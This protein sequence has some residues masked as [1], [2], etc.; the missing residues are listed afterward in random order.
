VKKLVKPIKQT[1]STF[2]DDETFLLEA[3]A[4]LDVAVKVCF[5]KMFSI[6]LDYNAL[7]ILNTH[8]K[9]HPIYNRVLQKARLEFRIIGD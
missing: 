1:V 7:C 8:L 6:G 9:N 4:R 3:K 2:S 5:R